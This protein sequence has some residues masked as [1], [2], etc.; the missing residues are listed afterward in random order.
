MTTTD[1]YA[2][3]RFADYRLATGGRFISM[4]GEQMV[5]VAIGWEVYERT[6]SAFALGGVGLAQVAPIILFSLIGGQVADTY[7]RRRV[8]AIAQTFLAMSMLTLAYLSATAGPIGFMYACLVLNGLC[9]AFNQPASR[10][11]TPLTVPTDV[12]PN[13]ATWNSSAAQ[14]ATIV[15]PSIGGALIAIFFHATPVFIA[16]AMAAALYGVFISCIKLRNVQIVR[17]AANWSGVLDGLRFIRATPIVFSAI[18]LDLLAVMF[19]GAVALLPI[20]AKDILQVGPVGLGW[21]QAAPALGAIVMAFIVAH[22]PPFKR[23][24]LTLLLAVGI[25][26]LATIIFGLSSFFPLSLAMLVVLGACDQ[27]SVVIRSTLILTR[28]PDEMRGRV[29]A[30]E[31]VFISSSNQLGSFESGLVAGF[32]GPI[33]AVVSGGV[34]AIGV[35]FGVAKTWPQLR[36]LGPLVDAPKDPEPIPTTASV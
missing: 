5:A 19:G 12:F 9:R 8:V 32:F 26:G 22:M 6:G 11:L 20:Y 25:Y 14:L 2:A 21:L 23:A 10:S 30:V 28:T 35:V 33:V 36:G 31:S 17:R 7:D 29:S 13:A 3:L 16:G 34:I 24:G 4:L 27:V 15:G 1:P 18:T